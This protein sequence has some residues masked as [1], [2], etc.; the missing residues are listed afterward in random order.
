MRGTL[1]VCHRLARRW[2]GYF[3][4]AQAARAG[5]SRGALSYHVGTGDLERVRRGLYRATVFPEHRFADI[6]VACL[7]VGEPVVAS[8]DTALVVHGV[9]DDLVPPVHVTVGR[10]FGGRDPGVVV[11]RRRLATAD[12]TKVDDV[13]VTTVERTFDDLAGRLGPMVLAPLLQA[14]VDRDVLSI[15]RLRRMACASTAIA[16]ATGVLL[17]HRPAQPIAARGA[18]FT[19]A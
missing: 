15:G 5:V 14:A 10:R 4:T 9:V 19:R 8:L 18:G 11:R 17:A 2:G 7:W 12:V 1:R 16:A 6:I 3:T 13:P